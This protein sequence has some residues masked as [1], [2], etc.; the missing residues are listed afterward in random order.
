ML[1]H[2]GNCWDY[3]A[4]GKDCH[5]GGCGKFLALCAAVLLG[6]LVVLGFLGL[7]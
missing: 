6:K 1:G 3:G 2:L 4:V 7:I 5:L